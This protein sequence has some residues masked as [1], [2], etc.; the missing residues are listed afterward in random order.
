MRDAERVEKRA[1]HCPLLGEVIDDERLRG[2]RV[3]EGRQARQMARLSLLFER[4][5]GFGAEF[6][7][8][9]DEQ[10]G[11]ELVVGRLLVVPEG[12]RR[13]QPLIAGHPLP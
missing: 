1:H 5:D 12:A 2:E 4:H 8:L 6:F 11:L 9:R 3:G 7:L 10:H 13:L